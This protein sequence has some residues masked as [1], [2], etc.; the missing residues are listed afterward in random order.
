MAQIEPGTLITLVT[1]LASSVTILLGCVLPAILEGR[2]VL[3][4]LEGMVRQPEVADDLRTTLI[5]AMALLEST[6][7]YVLLVVLILIFANPMLDRFFPP[8]G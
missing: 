8:G 5:V 7:I 2:A 6:A 3:K 1:I 4:A